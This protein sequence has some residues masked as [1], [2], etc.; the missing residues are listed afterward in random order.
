MSATALPK[1]SENQHPTSP[2]GSVGTDGGR[3]TFC[4]PAGPRFY[5]L[6]LSISKETLIC[7]IVRWNFEAQSL[8]WCRTL[9][10]I[11]AG[12]LRAALRAAIRAASE[13]AAFRAAMQLDLASQTPLILSAETLLCSRFDQ[14]PEY[15]FEKIK[16]YSRIEPMVHEVKIRN[17]DDMNYM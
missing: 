3:K 4:S 1:K 10:Q 14:I 13:R 17:S 5:M 2:A 8:T 16:S 6:I 12:P 7:F 9:L 15:P 11:F